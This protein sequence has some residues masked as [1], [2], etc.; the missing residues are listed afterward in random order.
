MNLGP[1]NSRRTYLRWDEGAAPAAVFEITSRSTR[2]EDRRTKRPLYQ[3]LGVEE[4]FLFDPLGDCLVPA[5]QGNC[6][7]GGT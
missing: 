6:L 1:R 3:R 7:V 4:Y 2:R 5:L